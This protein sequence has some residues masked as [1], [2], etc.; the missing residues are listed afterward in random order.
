MV[1]DVENTSSKDIKVRLESTV[2]DDNGA[3][4]MNISSN[5]VTLAPGEKTRL[6][7]R[8]YSGYTSYSAILRKCKSFGNVKYVYF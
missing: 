2:Y 4:S 6:V 5:I 7:A 3:V 1:V 8:K